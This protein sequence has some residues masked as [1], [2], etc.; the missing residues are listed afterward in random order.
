ML[1]LVGLIKAWGRKFALAFAALLLLTGVTVL[2]MGLKAP[3]EYITAYCYAVT[4]I[5]VALCGS[6][7]AIEWKNLSRPT[8]GTTGTPTEG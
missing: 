3:P 4:G 7:A 1:N 6:N 2:G 8:S 5:V